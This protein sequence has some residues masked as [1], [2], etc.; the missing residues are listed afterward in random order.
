MQINKALLESSDITRHFMTDRERKLKKRLCQ[1]LKDKGHRKYAERFWKLDFNIVDSTKHPDFTAAI[2]F[3]EATVFISDGFLGS[4]QGIF[5]QLDV[6]LRHE[7]AHNLMMHQIRLMYIFKKLHAND[8]DVA[9]EHIRYSASL[10]DILNIIEDFEISNKRYTAA[11]KKIVRTMQLNGEVIGGLV[12]EDHRDAWETLPL[13]TMYDELSKE[14]IQIN[15]DIRS[16]PDWAPTKSGY[17]WGTLDMLKVQGAKLIKA[18]SDFMKPSGIRAPIDIFIKSKA[19]SNYADIY[20]EL[21][22]ALYD[23][24]KDLTSDSEKQEILDLVEAISLT[25]PQEPFDIQHPKTG[26]IILTL[27]T[28]EDK[29]LATEVLKNLGGNINYNPQKFKVK[30]KTNS[31]EYIDAWNQVIKTL[32]SKQ[33]DDAVLTQIRDAIDSV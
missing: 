28:P 16:N 2:S 31:Q 1:L 17:S 26:E 8:P 19:F 23:A 4:G 6:L 30:K 3:D 7:L 13:E 12:T 33:F 29:M 14:L 27:Y 24:F 5:N 10:H 15:S 25:G 20:K 18:Y 21:V 11:D 9:Y 32:D 22:T